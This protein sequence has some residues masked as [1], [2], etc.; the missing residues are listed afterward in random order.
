MYMS[1]PD[2]PKP[3]IST[4][5]IT[6]R[7]TLILTD[8][9]LRRQS[10]NDHTSLTRPGLTITMDLTT[11]RNPKVRKVEH[12][13]AASLTSPNLPG[14]PQVDHTENYIGLQY[15]LPDD[16]DTTRPDT[17]RTNP[18]LEMLRDSK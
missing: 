11:L 10:G 4:S 18:V 1:F 14:S 6:V 5:H 2:S 8:A 7:R 12:R 17:A 15:T 9:P 3:P 13:N 16:P